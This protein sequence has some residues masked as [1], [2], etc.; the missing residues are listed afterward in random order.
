MNKFMQLNVTVEPQI[1]GISTFRNT[2]IFAEKCHNLLIH[3]G[4]K[5][6]TLDCFELDEQKLAILIQEG[7]INT[8]LFAITVPEIDIS[9]EAIQFNIELAA[10]KP[11]VAIGIPQLIIPGCVDMI[12]RDN[13]TTTQNKYPRRHLFQC[14]VNMT[15]MLANAMDNID[16]GKFI[17]H[18]ANKIMQ[19]GDMVAILIPAKPFSL[20]GEKL[21][22]WHDPWA[23]KAFFNAIIS[24]T[25]ENIPIKIVDAA[26][27]EQKFVDEAV[28]TMLMLIHHINLG[29]ESPKID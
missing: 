9:A 20:F 25:H 12:I 16:I 26:I 5:T 11:N 19:S 3:E 7:S 1:I 28:L 23:N 17:A 2:A 27:H 6:I 29:W 18:K 14:D 10:Y 24:N 8:G 15:A 4:Y 21:R 22:L 13:I